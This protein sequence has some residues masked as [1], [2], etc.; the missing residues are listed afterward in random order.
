[1]KNAIETK[2]N[3]GKE[4]IEINASTIYVVLTGIMPE[5]LSVAFNYTTRLNDL[6]DLFLMPFYYDKIS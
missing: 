6:L 2:Q 3:L 1:M 4:G 5:G